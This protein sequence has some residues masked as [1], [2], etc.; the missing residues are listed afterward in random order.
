MPPQKRGKKR[1]QTLPCFRVSA[2]HMRREKHANF[3]SSSPKPTKPDHPC[4]RGAASHW[5]GPVIQGAKAWSDIKASPKRHS[6]KA[7]LCPYGTRG[8]KMALL[9]PG[10]RIRK[11]CDTA[12]CCSCTSFYR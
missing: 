10:S 2:S 7:S 3:F 11:G 9:I 5:L 6:L 12:V 8:G 4:L 1:S